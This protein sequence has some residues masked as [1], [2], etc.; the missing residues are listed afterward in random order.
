ME[1]G[2]LVFGKPRIE[3]DE[4]KEVTDCLRSGW[5]GTGPRTR[6]FEEMFKEYKGSSHAIALN[7]CTAALHLALL[8]L[9]IS[10]G[11]EVIVPAMTFGATANAVVHAGAR[12]VFVDCEKDTGNMDITDLE[13]KI[14][15]RTKVII[16]VHFAGRPCKMD[17]ITAISEKRGIKI[18]EDCAH[19]LDGEYHG[20]KT[21]TMGDIGC[22]SFYATKN[23]VTGEGGMAVTD[24]EEY[25]RKIKT[26]SLHGITQDA[27][28][29][30]GGSTYRHYEVIYPGYKYNMTDIQS[31]IGIHQLPRVKEYRQSRAE[32]WRKYNEAFSSLPVFTPPGAEPDTEHSYHLYTLFLDTE[33]TPVKRDTFLN[34]MKKR[35]IGVG[36]HY[37][38]LHLHSYYRDTLGYR[39]GDFPNA[40]W[41][42]ERTVSLPLYPSLTDSDV[43]AVISA[44]RDILA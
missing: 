22:F 4:I 11:D 8:A 43:T 3:D 39:E 32:I 16:P 18:I 28:E 12:P 34:E 10:S 6:R 9:G 44:T 20:K 42:S 17:E 24:N 1:D 35:K 27:W 13:K 15:P 25:A 23:I 40:E 26:L 37:T 19:A 7:S 31:A 41:I 29:R 33:R 21:G 30:E 36:V 5:I 2:F 38:A 14:T